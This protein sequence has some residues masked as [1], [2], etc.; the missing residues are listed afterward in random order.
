MVNVVK[1]KAV[2]EN[3]SFSDE[4]VTQ[5][6]NDY[7]ITFYKKC[8][9]TGGFDA[10][11][12]TANSPHYLK[13]W[14]NRTNPEFY[15]C[16]KPS[17]IENSY[18]GMSMEIYRDNECVDTV[19]FKSGSTIGNTGNH[20]I[21]GAFISDYGISFNI[22]LNSTTGGSSG[23]IE[24]EEKALGT[25]SFFPIILVHDEVP[26]LIYEITNA[27][28][29]TQASSNQSN[30]YKVFSL[31]H[32]SYEEIIEGAHYIGY[33]YNDQK[34]LLTQAYSFEHPIN[35]PHLFRVIGKSSNTSLGR[36]MVNNK[37]LYWF[38]RFAL[39]FNE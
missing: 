1:N 11:I 23:R 37:K 27:N 9:T 14:L 24:T 32:E 30:T 18:L 16:I 5:L 31:N 3:I 20:F 26:T 33:N 28:P 39:E 36:I 2:L 21:M 12:I 13:V 17:I 34:M 15:I 10:E 8:F 6:E 29:S 35:T 38:G 7:I 25:I 19:S 22:G 4:A